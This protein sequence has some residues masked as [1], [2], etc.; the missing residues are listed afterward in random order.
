MH[1]GGKVFQLLS[2]GEMRGCL[3]DELHE[4]TAFLRSRV[5]EQTSS[6]STFIV[7]TPDALQDVSAG[8]INSWLQV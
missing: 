8:K 5:T 6:S 3:L 2:D 7:D 1:A 4:L